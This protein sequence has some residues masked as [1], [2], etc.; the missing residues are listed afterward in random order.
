MTSK[1]LRKRRGISEEIQRKIC[2]GGPGVGD[3]HRR[4]N[5]VNCLG[6][7]SRMTKTINAYNSPCWGKKGTYVLGE[8]FSLP[9]VLFK[10]VSHMP[11]LASSALL[12]AQFFVHWLSRNSSI[13]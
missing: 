8:P 7:M 6:T 12:Q 11:L 9:D 2:N 13:A 3:K 5:C 10:G 4:K 1:T